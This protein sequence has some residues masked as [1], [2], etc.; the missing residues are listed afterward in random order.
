MTRRA[1]GVLHRWP[2]AMP[3]LALLAALALLTVLGII[4][5]QLAPR[6]PPPAVSTTPESGSVQVQPLA[7]V[8]PPPINYIF[9]D[10]T[11]TDF[12][13][14][15]PEAG[16]L[17]SIYVVPWRRIHINDNQFDWRAI[18][19]YLD[20]AQNMTVTLDNGQVISKPV[21]L[22]I[23]D[24]ESSFP[25]REVGAP[26]PPLT[27]D[28]PM[29]FFA[30]YT[31]P[32]VRERL[33]SSIDP[34]T[35]VQ[36]LDPYREGRLTT[37]LGSYMAIG[38][39]GNSRCGWPFVAFAPKYN[40]PVW[41]TYYK[42]MVYALGQRYNNDP[43]VS[44]IILGPGI[45]SEYGQAT[46]P[47]FGCDIKSILYAQSGMNESEYLQTVIKP[48][49]LNDIADWYRDAF[50]TKQL[51]LQFTSAGKSQIDLLVAEGHTPPIGLKQATMVNDN[52][53]Q[54]QNDNSGTIQ[55]MMR[56]STTHSIAWENA[57][58]Y[59]GGYP[60]SNQVRYFT[61]LAGLTSF[62]H[63][64]DFVGG[65]PIEPATVE[66]GMFNFERKYLGRTITSTDEVWIALRDTQYWP[67]VGGALKFAGWHDDFTYGLSRPEGIP[68]NQTRVIT[69]T[70]LL[71]PPF[72][73]TY[74]ITTSLYSLIARRTDIASGNPYMSFAADHRWQYWGR[75]PISVAAD[76]V[77]YEFTLKYVDLGS[78]TI[79]IQYMD[80]SGI[81]RTR[82][83]RKRD[84]GQ[85]VTTTVTIRDA[86]LHGQFPGGAD[87]RI[88]AEPDAGGVDEII[89]MVMVKG[90]S[91][92]EPTPTPGLVARP[93]RTPLPLY[94]QWVNAGGGRYVDGKG[95]VW[96]AD[97]AYTP[98]GWGYTGGYT[99]TT[100]GS[101]K[102][103]EVDDPQLYATER[104][105]L[106]RGGYRFDVPNGT[107]DVELLFAETL[108]DG[109]SLRIFDVSI[110]DKPVLQ[111]FDI[112]ATAGGFYKGITL[113]FQTTVSD[114]QLNIDFVTRKETAKICAI[115]VKYV[116]QPSPTTP[117]ATPSLPPPVATSTPTATPTPGRA[118][119][120]PT[121][122]LTLEQ[123]IGSL[124][125]R[126]RAL[127]EAVQQILSQL[128]Q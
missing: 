104:Y 92:S 76:G 12:Q 111:N 72:N 24:N 63:F 82:S 58:S 11:N 25:N 67:P 6:L 80:Y 90:H 93:T 99:S 103:D 13:S 127:E 56:Y 83:I 20:A 26:I 68:G 14:L 96:A 120:T 64:M 47:I 81:T 4:G 121:P 114:G 89:H 88:S 23:L 36:S 51:Y 54:W 10:W 74:P 87:F 123:R 113:R 97:Q 8:T 32:F 115:H 30:D 28:S 57:Y 48:G 110:E 73:L 118:T 9:Y 5:G 44:A 101:Q 50:P 41:L 52:N 45:D 61:L 95:R 34:I 7:Q 35:W 85:W 77:F 2:W 116:N 112:W 69:T 106:D 27:P 86:Y 19:D 117:V 108:R 79:A 46:K 71:K 107:Y 122:T 75:L 100:T 109:K 84:S 91:G 62:P 105:W 42:Q 18:D 1:R 128:Q 78:D 70:D 126:Y 53:N 37:D 16:P 59:T 119:P 21:I 17:G 43:R 65:W 31:P 3:S 39:P 40:H 33:R 15:Y 124:E 55:L 125:E 102:V 22:E 60:E 29:F 38:R 94:E 66:T 49:P 98:G